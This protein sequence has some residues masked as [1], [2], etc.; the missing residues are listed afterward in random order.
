MLT[1]DNLA[2]ILESLVRLAWPCMLGWA[3]WY[4]R[5]EVSALL[6]KLERLKLPGGGEAYFEGETSDELS[7]KTTDEAGGGTLA[8]G[9]TE[10]MVAVVEGRKIVSQKGGSQSGVKWDRPANL[11]WLGYDL[12]TGVDR[13]G[14]G[15]PSEGV[16]HSL[17]QSWWHAKELGFSESS[18]LG[19]LE[20]LKESAKEVEEPKWDMGRRD[21]YIRE[22]YRVASEI[23]RLAIEQQPS[24]DPVAR[25]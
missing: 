24:F 19:R 25:E 21:R 2:P 5:Y 3:L 22:L 16:I 4:Y 6:R 8:V 7:Q 1:A 10:P 23:E 17:R 18:I 14:F 11:F 15:A 20:T 9:K 12:A 13:L